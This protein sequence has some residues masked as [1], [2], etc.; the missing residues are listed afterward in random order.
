MA[1]R[2][3]ALAAL[4]TGPHKPLARYVFDILEVY[5]GFFAIVAAL[6][7]PSPTLYTID[8]YMSL[9]ALL[10]YAYRV[11]LSP[12]PMSYI[13]MTAWEI[14]GMIPLVAVD[15]NPLASSIVRAAR[16]ARVAIML[17]YG[18]DLAR[19]LRGFI[20]GLAL[21][22]IFALFA[23]T[24]TTGSLAY[25]A[26]EAG[27]S[28]HSYFDALWFTIVTITT[29]GY[30]DIVPKT[31]AG[32]ALTM[33]LMAIGIVLWSVTIAVFSSAA[34]R[35]VGRAIARELQRLE[36]KRIQKLA[37]LLGYPLEAT[38][39]LVG[40]KDDAVTTCILAALNL[41]PDEFEEFL[42]ELRKRYWA[43]HGHQA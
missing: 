9:A 19:L 25:Y 17:A 38:M 35:S 42:E 14:P 6:A 5:L 28:V 29:V 37:G 2:G 36:R 34:A 30:G 13:V 20:R 23:M 24:I 12:Y 31:T 27:H 21:S 18:S 7:P 15:T 32:K 4:A 41:P 39:G 8:F 22:P 33:V 26:V 43:I 11:A 10:A 1:A 3:E 40:E 16:I